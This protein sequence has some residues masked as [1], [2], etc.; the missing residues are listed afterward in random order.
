MNQPENETNWFPPPEYAQAVDMPKPGDI[1]IITVEPG[2]THTMF[3]RQQEGGQASS[4]DLVVVDMTDVDNTGEFSGGHK[5][6]GLG[7]G[8]CMDCKCQNSEKIG[9]DECRSG[10][11]NSFGNFDIQM[12][13]G[14]FKM[15]PDPSYPNECLPSYQDYMN[16]LPTVHH[17]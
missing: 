3:P 4:E 1:L 17:M 7:F 9:C 13:S 11:N 14:I 6:R 15:V 16:E 5:G 12:H 10:K 2:T 8:E